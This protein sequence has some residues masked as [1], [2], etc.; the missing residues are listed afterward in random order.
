MKK[1][2]YIIG[3]SISQKAINLAEEMKY[4]P[5]FS[6]LIELLQEPL[7]PSFFQIL[8]AGLRLDSLL[9]TSKHAVYCFFSLLKLLDIPLFMHTAFSVGASTTA[10]LRS[11]IPDMKIH[12]AKEEQ[13]EGILLAIQKELPTNLFWPR[14]MDA[15]PF[16][17]QK[18]REEKISC[19]ELPLYRPVHIKKTLPLNDGDGIFF[20]SPS[21][22]DA[23][24]ACHPHPMNLAF[25]SI[26][27]ITKGK[28]KEILN[29][30]TIYSSSTTLCL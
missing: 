17:A 6:P 10:A 8:Q 16:L 30:S 4:E 25:Y 3:P 1:K 22:V 13:Q 9:F 2:L 12:T 29:G 21:S 27:A 14:S 23:F 20:S 28:I 26:G 15:R 24:F 18:L 19:I 5:I 11:Y 7:T